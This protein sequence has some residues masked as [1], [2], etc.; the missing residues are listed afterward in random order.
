MAKLKAVYKSVDEIPEQF[1]ELYA[2]VKGQFELVEV[3]GVKTV[4][5]VKRLTEALT[6]ER[7]LHKQTKE[8]WVTPWGERDI[9]VELPKLE[10]LP[11]L[12]ATVETLKQNSKFD[13]TKMESIIN[14]RVQSVKEPL[15]RHSKK[16]QSE[17]DA[18]RAQ[19]TNYERAEKTRKIHDVVR[20]EAT[21]S[22]LLKET[23]ATA[24]S[25]LMMLAERHLEVTA[26]GA[27][28]TREGSGIIAGLL[29]DVWLSEVTDKH[30]YLKP[31]SAGGGAS[32]S[33]GSGSAF[34]G[35][36]PFTNEHFNVT[37]QGRIFREDPKKA[38]TLMRLA[39]APALG[40]RPPK[41]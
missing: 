2:D 11:E 13:E 12:H 7:N 23:Y 16:L 41:K 29:P 21:K 35:K 9:A 14:A 36:N 5:D 25:A 10:T 30:P 1:R 32:G 33:G 28:V 38:E 24:D 27:V 37:E 18:A 26:D 34:S 6:A 40:V 39:G 31:A 8:K 17:L 3:E 4:E 22:N 20:A 19:V 15:D